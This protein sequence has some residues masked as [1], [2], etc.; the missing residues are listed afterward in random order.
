MRL[1]VLLNRD[2]KAKNVSW[3]IIYQISTPEIA[4]YIEQLQE[5]CSISL[6]MEFARYCFKM[7]KVEKRRENKASATTLKGERSG[8]ACSP[9]A[10][11]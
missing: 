4:I 10:E 2:I 5:L 11:P 7:K 8:A 6:F 9:I 1:Q 3:L